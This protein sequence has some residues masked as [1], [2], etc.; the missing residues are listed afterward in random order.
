MVAS[1]C[2]KR[3]YATTAC[4]VVTNAELDSDGYTISEEFSLISVLQ[5]NEIL[6]ILIIG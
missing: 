2:N 6:I 5:V 1:S 4:H 3:R